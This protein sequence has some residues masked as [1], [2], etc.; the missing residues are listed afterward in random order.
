MVAGAAREKAAGPDGAMGEGLGLLAVWVAGTPRPKQSGRMVGGKG[1]P[2]RFVTH[3]TANKPAK[4]WRERVEREA[5][6]AAGTVAGMAAGR[7]ARGPIL[8]RL[9]FV[10]PTRDRTRWG[11]A[12]TARPDADNLAKLALDALK[13]A[14]WFGDDAQAARLEVA[15]VWGPEHA[16]GMGAELARLGAAAEGAPEAGQDGVGDGLPGWLVS[17]GGLG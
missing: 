17:G 2:A 14:G 5:R 11:T 1:G 8:V 6:E 16:K 3:A 10:F 7:Q 15:K 13:A 4:V 12:H 9:R